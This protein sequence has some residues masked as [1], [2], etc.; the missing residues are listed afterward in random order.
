M[1]ISEKALEIYNQIN[2][3]NTKLGD[4][5]K[6][7]KD[8]KK[9]HTLSLELWSAGKFFPRM[10]AVLIMD[11]KKIN[12]EFINKIDKDIQEHII[13]ERIQLA[14]WFMANQLTK[15]KR[16]IALIETWEKSDSNIQRRI[17]WYYQARLRWMGKTN[18]ANTEELLNLIEK[19]ILS[20]N[21][22]VQWAMN[23]TAGQ[24]GKWEEKYRAR[25]IAIGENTGLYKDE[26]VAKNCTPSY[27]PEFIRIEVNKINN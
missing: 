2:K 15:D 9:D 24:I 21:E 19:N 27:L 26:M 18:H 8:I 4:L 10:L 22:I 14:D 16:T 7:A 5:R 11:V 1:K 3:D 12:Q 6:I 13:D 20:E 25:C 17:F 23:Y